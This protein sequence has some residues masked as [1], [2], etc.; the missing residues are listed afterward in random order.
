MLSTKQNEGYSMK[1]ERR[2]NH[3]RFTF[4]RRDSDNKINLMPVNT[5]NMKELAEV[6]AKHLYGSRD[7]YEHMQKELSEQGYFILEKKTEL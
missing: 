2:S 1:T 6:V 5:E 7:F 4:G 3:R